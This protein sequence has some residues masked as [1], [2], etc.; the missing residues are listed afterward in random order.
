MEGK[1][2]ER[3]EEGKPEGGKE[4]RIEEGKTEGWK[5]RRKKGERKE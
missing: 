2:E 4:G 3:I 5:I 1:K